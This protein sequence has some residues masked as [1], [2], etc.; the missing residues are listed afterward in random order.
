MHGSAGI[1]Y[2]TWLGIPALLVGTAL[3]AAIRSRRV[4]LTSTLTFIVLAGC[5]FLLA[6]GG[7]GKPGT[8]RG[9]YPIAISGTSGGASHT[10]SVT[11]TVQ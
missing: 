7:G 6:C 8:T 10:T 3:M 11:L 9:T 1:L 5:L 4:I 2:A